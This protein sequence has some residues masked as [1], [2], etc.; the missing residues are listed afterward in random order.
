MSSH[1]IVYV[2]PGPQTRR[3]PVIPHSCAVSSDQGR[4]S[5]HHSFPFGHKM[6]V[7]AVWWGWCNRL[8]SIM[9]PA[10]SHPPFTQEIYYH[11]FASNQPPHHRVCH[12]FNCPL[13]LNTLCSSVSNLKSITQHL[14]TVVT[15]PTSETTANNP[16]PTDKGITLL[17][18]CTGFVSGYC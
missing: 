14:I 1:I 10:Y 5:I 17:T 3:P 12:L 16:T 8:V 11:I 18:P 13:D 6:K 7:W 2:T 4:C 9:S 15:V